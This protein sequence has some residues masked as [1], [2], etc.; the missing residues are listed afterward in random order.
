MRSATSLLT[1]G[2]VLGASATATAQSDAATAA[3]LLRSELPGEHAVLCDTVAQELSAAGFVVEEINGDALCAAGDLTPERYALL[4]I[5]NAGSLPMGS[6]GAIVRYLE[7]GGD[8]L[9]LRTPMGR[10]RLIQFDGQWIEP[11][12][13]QRLRAGDVPP[14]VLFAFE[15]DDIVTWQRSAF[16]REQ[17]VEY[18]T[19]ADGPA[20]GQRALHV[21][22]GSLDGWDTFGPQTITEPFPD[23]HTLTLFSA[24][25]D[26]ATPQLSIEWSEHDGSRWIAVI[27]LSDEWRQY[28]LAPED[29]KFWESVPT[30]AGSC[31]QPEN[32]ARMCVGLSFTHTGNAGGRHEF[33]MGPFGTAERGPEHEAFLTREELPKLDTLCPSYKYFPSTDV[34]ILGAA[35]GESLVSG[36]AF[37]LTRNVQCPH[38]RPEAG[39]FDKGREWRWMPVLEARTKAGAWRGTPATMM[40]HVDGPWKGGVWAACG[41]EDAD[42]YLG[43][44][45]RHMVHALAQRMREPLCLVDG[46]ADFYT[47]FEDQ[48]M[49]LG[50]RVADVG[51]DPQKGVVARVVVEDRADGRTVHTTPLWP[52]EVDPGETVTQSETWTPSEWP[53]A[54][55]TVKAELLRDG[56]VVDWAFHEAHVWRPK[57]EPQF[58][59][60]ADGDFMLDGERWRPHGVNYMP[61][62]GIGTEDGPYFEYWLGARSYDPKIVQRDLEHVRDLGFNSVSV[63]IYRCSM[64]AQN[65]LDL[66]RRLDLLDLKANLSLRPGTPMDLRWDDVRALIEY[67]RLW[68]Q[69]TVFALDLA[70][71]PLFDPEERDRWNEGWVE[72]IVERYGSVE[73]AE[74]DWGVPVPRDGHGRIVNIDPENIGKETRWDKMIAAYRRFLD[75]LL[76]QQ[77]S[78]ARTLV[79]TLD[80]KHPVSFRMSVAGDPTY[81]WPPVMP[82]DFAYLAG[83]VDVLEPEAYGRIGDWERV[84]AG[85]FTFE[86]ARWANP[87]LP[88]L[89]AEAGVHAWDMAR[90]ESSPEKLQFQ[91]E[92]YQRLYRM[93]I[94]SGADGIF[95]W[96]Y[97]G[98]FRTGENS[99][100]GVINPDGSY[101]P[102]SRVIRKYAQAFIQGP[103]ANPVDTWLVMDRDQ[104]SDGLPGIYD[105]L[106]TTFWEAVDSGKTPGLKTSA[107][108]S[109]SATCPLIAVGNS[110]HNGSNPPKHLDGFF[111]RV[112]VRDATGQWIE[113]SKGGRVEVSTV[114]VPTARLTVTNL[115]EASWRVSR[116][117]QGPGEA[118]AA[119]TAPESGAANVAASA[120]PETAEDLGFVHVLAQGRG[121]SVKTLLPQPLQRF[122]TLTFEAALTQGPPA[123]SEDI[124]LTFDARGRASFGPKFNLTIMPVASVDNEKDRTHAR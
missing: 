28:V 48:P 15:P 109:D 70:W 31:F 43:D 62:S 123:E 65:L 66:L 67:Y 94:S 107:T 96:W 23:G 3:A 18:E 47:Y 92:F 98:G 97:P 8:I 51:R 85:C 116:V 45:A 93:L 110:P 42:W 39:G 78:R 118:S 35:P 29:F 10:A 112:E 49:R 121:N 55:F 27:P 95:F 56:V 86:Y 24:R 84:K 102:V 34:G 22:I 77:Y 114:D 4:A 82:Y 52:V 6:A 25:G 91:A 9:A 115:G 81:K 21:T 2:L 54:G 60:V 64:E 74:A 38:P 20:P 105:E 5:P 113:L 11:W 12:T 26:A 19:L 59:T 57:A 30:R 101:R 117:S 124:V 76:Y 119:A 100:Y 120:G 40:W 88:L 80:D 99:D 122:E 89:W 46:G 73:N 41:I 14:N 104:H 79:R 72:W 71:E 103:A 16:R 61:S 68:E 53:Q 33:W 87:A 108:G 37:P 7:L 83:A 58:V 106:A 63:F 44:E 90:M 36:L 1:L 111:D 50:V 32:A 13:F 75:T 17:P 69:D